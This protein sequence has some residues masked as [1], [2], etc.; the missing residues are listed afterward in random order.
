MVNYDQSC[1]E[2]EYLIIFIMLDYENDGGHHALLLLANEPEETQEVDAA[3][4]ISTRD[5][6]DSSNEIDNCD[7]VNP[8]EDMSNGNPVPLLELE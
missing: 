8:V 5:S 4:I 3:N 2:L 7:R 1:Y 6:D